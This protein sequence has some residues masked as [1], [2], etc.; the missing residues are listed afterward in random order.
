MP[1]FTAA[2]EK[3]TVAVSPENSPR[4]SNRASREIVFCRSFKWR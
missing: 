4:P 2:G 1:E 3:V